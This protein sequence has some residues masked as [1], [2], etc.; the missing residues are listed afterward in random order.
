MKSKKFLMALLLLVVCVGCVSAI[1]AVSDEDINNEVLKVDQSDD[2]DSL[3]VDENNLQGLAISQDEIVLDSSNFEKVGVDAGAA[4][5]PEPAPA[6]LSPYEQFCKDLEENQG[7]IYLT[8]DIKIS[9]EFVIKHPVVIDGNGHTIDAQHKS[10]I[11]KSTST[12]TIKNL[13]LINGKSS[14]KGGAIN[15]H[16]DLTVVNCKFVNNVAKGC[17]GAISII[18]GHLTVTNCI[19]EKNSV[20]STGSAGYGGAIWVYSS[21]SK[22]TG[23]T[24]TSNGCIAKSLKNH[25]KAT[26]YKFNG[27]AITFSAGSTHVVDNCKFNG[28]K[29]SNHGGAI[30]VINSKSVKVNKC[31]FNKNRAAYE[32]G[33]AISFA[34]KKLQISN[35]IFKN[36]LAFEDGGAIDAYSVSGKKI[37]III[38]NCKFISNTAYKCA[39]AI[40]MGVKTSFNVANSQFIKNK[41]NNAGAVDT[42]SGTTKFTKCTFTGNKAAKI[43]SWTVKTKSGAR[44]AH[45]GGAILVKNHCKI[46]K[47]KFKKN[48][49]K[50]GNT[51]KVEGGKVTAKG[52]K[53]YSKK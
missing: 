51:V 35:S 40:W 33:G 49:A 8:G 1:S 17:G 39:G 3:G 10:R 31:N 30:F 45:S 24:F 11:F 23:S 32:D 20:E 18:Y 41:A 44:L 28:N 27:G 7:T 38:S 29:A 25:K 37:S 13:V 5:S 50:Y 47:C 9:Q 21:S 52:N 26:S 4:A 12:L 16:G 48:K 15:A 14:D 6:K 42:E 19:F 22:I 2:I 43:T 46:I 34:G 53:G 36:N